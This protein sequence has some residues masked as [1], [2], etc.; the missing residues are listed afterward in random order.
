MSSCRV[1]TDLDPSTKGCKSQSADHQQK[2]RALIWTMK[3]LQGGTDRML[4]MRVALTQVMHGKH[5]AMKSVVMLLSGDMPQ[6]PL[7]V[8]LSNEAD[9]L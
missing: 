3:E 5:H 4:Q 2:E 6:S 7:P 1:H 8:D 9:L